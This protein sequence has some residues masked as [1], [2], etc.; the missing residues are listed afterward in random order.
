MRIEEWGSGAT[1][2]EKD[3][4]QLKTPTDVLSHVKLITS[5]ANFISKTRRA[6]DKKNGGRTE[7]G[8]LLLP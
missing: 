7:N 5:E 3:K 4:A 8:L 1:H 2:R 6:A